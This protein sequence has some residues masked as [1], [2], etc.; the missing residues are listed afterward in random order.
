[1]E[2]ICWCRLRL[3][4]RGKSHLN[5]PSN[6]QFPRIF[7]ICMHITLWLRRYD[8][9]NLWLI[10]EYFPLAWVSFAI[11]LERICQVL[12][13]MDVLCFWVSLTISAVPNLAVGFR[14]SIL[15][16]PLRADIVIAF[17]IQSRSPIS[18]GIDLLGIPTSYRWYWMLTL[19][20]RTCCAHN[21]Q[22]DICIAAKCCKSFNLALWIKH[23]NLEKTSLCGWV[24]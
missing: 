7:A 2:N 11:W 5:I 19:M 23:I 20:N 12:L 22:K 4:L 9:K 14:S 21:L 18:F 16:R 1:M 6:F 8:S 13:N 17:F 3:R 15:L 24:D 10:M